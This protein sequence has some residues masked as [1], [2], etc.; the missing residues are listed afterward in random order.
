[1][2]RLYPG[3]LMGEE[4]RHHELQEHPSAGMAQSQEPGDGK[5]APRPLLR[6]L[7]ERLL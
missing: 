4:G 2:H 3:E 1:M 7:A 6:R 5:A